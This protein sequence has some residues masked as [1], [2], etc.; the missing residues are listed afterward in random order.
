MLLTLPVP[1][2]AEA[3]SVQAKSAIVLCAYDG[4]TL[5]AKNAD[6]RCLIA[7]TTKLMT[8]LVCLEHAALDDTV[9]AQDR[10]CAVEGSSM[11]LKAG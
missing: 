5:F 2:H 8:A 3:A 1:A 11:Y 7:S 4:S 10:H 9:T 6:S